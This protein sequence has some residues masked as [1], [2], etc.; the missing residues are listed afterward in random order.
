MF[1]E[2][3]SLWPTGM[4]EIVFKVP[5][6]SN[7]QSFFWRL[8][9][10]NLESGEFVTAEGGSSQGVD[11]WWHR[12]LYCLPEEQK[13]WLP[14]SGA[15]QVAS[16]AGDHRAH[17]SSRQPTTR[18]RYGLGRRPVTIIK[19]RAYTTTT[20]GLR[21]KRP[22]LSSP[23]AHDKR[24]GAPFS[25]HSHGLRKVLWTDLVESEL[26]DVDPAV[27]LHDFKDPKAHHCVLWFWNRPGVPS[28]KDKTEETP[29]VVMA[30]FAKETGI[31]QKELN[32]II[33][34]ADEDVSHLHISQVVP[35]A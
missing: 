11:R 2:L 26:R 5:G 24:I 21:C 15:A 4:F 34:P 6:R 35:V 23:L 14:G 18:N 29:N 22:G 19:N 17:I 1:N 10:L 28:P 3:S 7:P 12:F 33:N 8:R 9:D 13:Y 27:A 30:L 20:L 32:K 31:V 25:T 16:S